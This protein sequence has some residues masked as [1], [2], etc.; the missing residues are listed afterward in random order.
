MTLGIDQDAAFTLL[1]FDRHMENTIVAN[2]SMR[3]PQQF[4]RSDPDRVTSGLR[5]RSMNEARADARDRHYNSNPP[6]KMFT[7]HR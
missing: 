5:E 1:V 7:P 6:Q 4:V 3:K 2:P